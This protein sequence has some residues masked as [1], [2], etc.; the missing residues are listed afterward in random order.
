MRAEKF[1]HNFTQD[2]V[3]TQ[4]CTWVKHLRVWQG[5]GA[6]WSAFS[7]KVKKLSIHLKFGTE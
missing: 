4:R 7:K 5:G 3:S 2:F 1:C 6:Q